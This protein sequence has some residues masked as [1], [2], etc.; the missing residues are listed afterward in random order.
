MTYNDDT[1]P[2]QQS[3][4]SGITPEKLSANLEEV[5]FHARSYKKGEIFAFMQH[6]LA[7]LTRNDITVEELVQLTLETGK[8]G[9]SAMAQL[10]KPILAATVT[11]KTAERHGYIGPLAVQ[12]TDTI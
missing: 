10:I 1:Y 12:N 5:N 4:I 8:H 7:E 9:I 3:A 11:P 6:A 2:H